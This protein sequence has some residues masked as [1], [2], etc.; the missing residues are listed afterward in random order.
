MAIF[1]LEETNNSPGETLRNEHIFRQLNLFDLPI[2]NINKQKTQKSKYELNSLTELV[3]NIFFS[4][5]LLFLAFAFPC[6]CFSFRLLSLPFAFP[7][8][9]FSFRL[10]FPTFAFPKYQLL[11]DYFLYIA[12]SIQFL[13]IIQNLNFFICH[14]EL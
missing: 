1:R 11:F 8:V 13:F 14:F 2:S 3:P 12:H 10:L 6:V 5:R 7:S 9:C 4:L